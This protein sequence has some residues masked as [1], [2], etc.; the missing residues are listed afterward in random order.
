MRQLIERRHR[1]ISDCRR[2]AGGARLDIQRALGR[3]RCAP[4]LM[5]PRQPGLSCALFLCR[6]ALTRS[7]FGI[8]ALQ[9]RVACTRLL[10][11]RRVGLC[12]RRHQNRKRRC[13]YQT[14]LEIPGPGGNHESPEHLRAIQV[15]SGR[16]T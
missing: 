9:K 1:R 13:Q 2:D 8:S 15:V 16:A 4:G 12:C 5:N 11:F 6:Q 3:G 10:P 7:T 14:E